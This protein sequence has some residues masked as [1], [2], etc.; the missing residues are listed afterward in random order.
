MALP[1]MTLPR[2][3][4]SSDFAA[5]G[6]CGPSP[7]SQVAYCP[8]PLA[9]AALSCSARWPVLPFLAS[10]DDRVFYGDERRKKMTCGSHVSFFIWMDFVGRAVYVV[11]LEEKNNSITK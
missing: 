4:C 10:V 1:D 6:R 5:G 8:S 7:P 3:S 11:L 9:Y 2:R